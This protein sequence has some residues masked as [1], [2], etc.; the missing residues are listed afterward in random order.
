M[1]VWEILHV[2][3][4]QVL[5]LHQ[6]GQGREA[7]V[8]DVLVIGRVELAFFDEINDFNSEF[9]TFGET[10]NDLE[11]NGFGY[12]QH[13]GAALTQKI[14]QTQNS[15]KQINGKMES[16]RN[17]TA[18]LKEVS[19]LFENFDSIINTQYLKYSSELHLWDKA[20]NSILDVFGPANEKHI[21]L[22]FQNPAE[23]RPG[24]GFIGSYADMTVKNGQLINLEVQDIYWPDHPTNFKLK[25]VPPEPLQTITEDW[26]ASDANWFF[27]F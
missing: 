3:E 1:D 20:L 13:N 5:R 21:L 24:G 10:L 11:T 19:E 26:G 16:I 7:D 8:G 27:D 2:V 9:L 14:S 4:F 18:N 25:V 6:G 12:F 17:T 23:I 22:I 15:L